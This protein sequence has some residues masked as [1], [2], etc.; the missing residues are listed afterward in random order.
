MTEQLK[1]IEQ[2]LDML[3]RSLTIKEG[4]RSILRKELLEH[5][6]K[7]SVNKQF[8]KDNDILQILLKHTSE[9]AK[10]TVKTNIENIVSSA[11]NVIYGG[12]HVFSITVEDRR[13]QHEV[14]YWLD[15]GFAK[16][17]LKKPF[18]GKGGGKIT[19]VALALQLAIIEQLEVE[20]PIFLDEV[21]KM[22]DSTAILNLGF[23]LKEYAQKF[24]RQVILVTHH[25]ELADM[26]DN[27]LCVTKKNGIATVT[28]GD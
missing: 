17:Q 26:S 5:E 25:T 21:G 20:G 16:V 27:I 15:D 2:H 18:A 4:E 28:Y 10:T 3:S 24:K 11:L 19:V 14:D 1:Q 9:Y 12:S 13:N 6:A 8:I 23:F 22:I 7:L